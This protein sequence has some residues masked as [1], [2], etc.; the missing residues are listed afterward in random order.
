MGNLLLLP[1]RVSVLKRRQLQMKQ[2]LYTLE[3]QLM[4][5]K[6]DKDELQLKIQGLRAAC[7]DALRE[8]SRQ[9]SDQ[10]TAKPVQ[11]A[12]ETDERRQEEDIEN[13]GDPHQETDDPRQELSANA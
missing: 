1:N 5:V 6:K 13:F 9:S 12:N 11:F 4:D 2:R 3:R 8:L 10:Q 7:H